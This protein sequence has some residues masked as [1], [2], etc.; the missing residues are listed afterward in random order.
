[1][2]VSKYK[3]TIE[4]DVSDYDETEKCYIV[5]MLISLDNG[6]TYYYAGHSR[7]FETVGDALAYLEA[8]FK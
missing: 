7:I 8:R 3:F 4:S 5:K 6:K 1:M 2:I